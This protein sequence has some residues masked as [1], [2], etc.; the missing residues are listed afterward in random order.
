MTTNQ[1]YDFLRKE[2][3]LKAFFIDLLDVTVPPSASWCPKVGISTYNQLVDKAVKQSPTPYSALILWS[4]SRFGSRV[5]SNLE[6]PWRR[7]K[8]RIDR[9]GK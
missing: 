5:Y 4:S 1:F 3:V 8:Q 2:G 7:Y 6:G 9:N